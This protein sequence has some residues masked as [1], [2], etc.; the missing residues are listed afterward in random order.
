MK[1]I[2]RMM[3]YLALGSVCY[4]PLTLAS[5]ALTADEIAAKA[6][7]MALY[8][9]Q[10]SKGKVAMTITDK[11]GHIRKRTF[12]ILRKDVSGNDDDQMY[13]TLFQR[14]ADVRNMVFMVHKHADAKQDDDR[15][16]YLPSLDLVKRI[17]ASDKRTSFVGSDFLYEDI[18]GRSLTDDTHQLIET[19][20]SHYI[21]KN[22]PNNPMSV[23][24]SYYL[25]YIDKQSFL[26]MKMTFFKGSDQLYRVIETLQVEGVHTHENGV[27]AVYPSVV[28]SVAKDLET[29]TTTEMVFSNIQY[30]VGLKQRLFS[31]RFLRRPPRD[32]IR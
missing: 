20:P 17:A 5:I 7:H 8:Q 9:G 11:S 14:P 28:K 31:E 19:T 25:T 13:Y 10:D 30:N 16:L 23:E 4:I 2:N 27:D 24:F 32:A 26:P 29:H 12:T 18:S 3:G 1:R 6:N 21:L 15:W 22:T